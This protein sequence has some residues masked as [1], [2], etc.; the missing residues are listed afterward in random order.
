MSLTTENCA[1]NSTGRGNSTGL[2]KS[3]RPI[4]TRR[5]FLWSLRTCADADPVWG[6]RMLTRR[7]FLAAFG[8]AAVG[9]ALDPD[10]LAW[11]AG[12]RSFF[13]PPEG[14]L[15]R[16][17][18]LGLNAPVVGETLLP[19]DLVT[20]DGLY[21]RNPLTGQET[22]YHQFFIIKTVTEHTAGWTEADVSR[23]LHP[24]PPAID[25]GGWR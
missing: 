8:A 13:L 9:V 12:A 4:L 7:S 6:P 2:Y 19:G 25:R 22:L 17:R 24:H 1:E 11:R 15:Y 5:G 23:C 16:V 10:Q 20:I 3:D 14:R 18:P 21:T